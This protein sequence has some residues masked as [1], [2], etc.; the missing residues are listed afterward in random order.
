MGRVLLALLHGISLPPSCSFPFC[1]GGSPTYVILPFHDTIC[2]SYSSS[3]MLGF[4]KI[5]LLHH[6]TLKETPKLFDLCCPGCSPS[7][8][9]ATQI[10]PM[11]PQRQRLLPTSHDVTETEI[12]GFTAGSFSKW[13]VST[14]LGQCIAKASCDIGNPL[15]GW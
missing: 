1:H 10:V 4:I 3:S 13:P 8:L 14:G 7:L 5:F 6:T 11:C 12:L 15:K 2:L 9:S